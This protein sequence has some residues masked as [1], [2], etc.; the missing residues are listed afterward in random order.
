MIKYVVGFIFSWDKKSVI[1][2]KKQHPEWQK[3]RLNGIGG[4]I[5][6]KE[7]AVAAMQRECKEETGLDLPAWN[8]FLLCEDEDKK[9][10]L[11]CFR[12][13][14]FENQI[15]QAKTMTDEAISVVDAE[16]A[17]NLSAQSMI[18]N[19]RVILRMAMDWNFKLGKMYVNLD[20]S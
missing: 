9:I 6:D 4:H 12:T 20:Q 3:G 1:L 16:N 8:E 10:Q 7:T 14:L 18:G 19:L 15:K 13:V 5:N 11:H 17:S 2:I